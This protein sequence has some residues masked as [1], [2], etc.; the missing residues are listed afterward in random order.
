MMPTHFEFWRCYSLSSASLSDSDDEPCT[1]IGKNAARDGF[2]ATQPSQTA[3][4]CSLVNLRFPQVQPCGSEKQ[5]GLRCVANP[6]VSAIS[7]SVGIDTIGHS[8]LYSI[9]IFFVFFQKL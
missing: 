1:V 3:S 2:S 5:K 7:A 4:T 9:F 8:A 6:R